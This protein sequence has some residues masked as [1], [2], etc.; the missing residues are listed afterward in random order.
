MDEVLI[1]LEKISSTLQESVN[2]Y[3]EEIKQTIQ[4]AN[5]AGVTQ[6]I[7]FRLFMVGSHHD[8]FSNGVQFEMVRRS[9]RFDV[10]AAGGR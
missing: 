4:Y 10:L 2:P 8:H 9:R 1:R 7:F 3:L 5:L 6:P